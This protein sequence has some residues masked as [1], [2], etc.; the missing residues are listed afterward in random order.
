MLINFFTGN[1][2][3]CYKSSA[4]A[5][6]LNSNHCIMSANDHYDI[7]PPGTDRFKVKNVFSPQ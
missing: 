6:I 1:E 5:A 2:R 7:N 4:M 3:G